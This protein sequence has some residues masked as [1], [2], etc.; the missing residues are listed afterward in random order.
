MCF[1]D[2]EEGASNSRE[3]IRN[4]IQF[5]KIIYTE[6]CPLHKHE[7]TSSLTVDIPSL[8]IVYFSEIFLRIIQ[9]I[10]DKLL[11]ALTESDPYL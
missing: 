11:W 5:E 10:T 9:Y 6:Q 2:Q 3:M 8:K 4:G 7:F 1:K